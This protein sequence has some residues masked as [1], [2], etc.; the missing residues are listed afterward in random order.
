MSRK[1]KID[2]TRIFNTAKVIADYSPSTFT[3]SSSYGDTFQEKQKS[4][5]PM[6]GKKSQ[7][8]PNNVSFLYE[9]P[10]FINEPICFSNTKNTRSIQSKWWPE[11]T[12]VD[13]KKI[14]QYKEDTVSRSDYKKIYSPPH[15]LTR[16]GCNP[17]R[18]RPAIGIVPSNSDPQP[19]VARE[20]ISYAH[21]FD[22]RKGR[23]ER[24]KL[25]GSFVWE[26]ILNPQLQE[27]IKL[28]LQQQ[29]S[30]VFN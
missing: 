9:N 2:G 26:P 12:T 7:P 13:E 22:C 19:L 17:N 5:S 27:R 4:S 25:H 24:G 21:Q 8:D 30:N 28:R 10:R 3:K 16:F 15:G 29:R 20:K 23:K 11:T 6:A 1:K 18:L 14:P